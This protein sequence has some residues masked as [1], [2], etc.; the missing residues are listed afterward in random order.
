LTLP[1]AGGVFVNHNVETILSNKKGPPFENL[2]IVKSMVEHF[3][4]DV[5]HDSVVISAEALLK[6]SLVAQA[7]V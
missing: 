5:S 2:V 4:M 7:N 1:Q 3:E 6:H